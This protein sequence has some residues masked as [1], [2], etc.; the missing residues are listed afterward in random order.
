MALDPRALIPWGRS[1]RLSGRVLD[2][3]PYGEGDRGG[4]R[5][6]VPQGTCLPVIETLALDS[7]DAD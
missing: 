4:V 2:L 3:R 7:A 5:R 1:I 6:L